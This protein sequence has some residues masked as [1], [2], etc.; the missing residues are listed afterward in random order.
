[1]LILRGRVV[2]YP[3]YIY[4]GKEIPSAIVPDDIKSLSRN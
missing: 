3:Q 2:H 1:M 4:D